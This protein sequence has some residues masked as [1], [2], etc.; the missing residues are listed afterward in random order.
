M[1]EQIKTGP[2]LIDTLLEKLFETYA[3]HL[4][5]DTYDWGLYYTN[6]A[7][8]TDKEIY[9]ALKKMLQPISTLTEMVMDMVAERL[10]KRIKKSIGF[11]VQTIKI[12]F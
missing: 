10:M 11:V 9:E 4:W 7:G 2:Q 3:D 12:I 1:S 5:Y 6:Q 8:Y